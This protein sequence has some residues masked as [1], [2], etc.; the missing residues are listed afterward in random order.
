LG[1]GERARGALLGL[2]AGNA[3]GVPTEFLGS[4][5]AIR[6]AFP[7]GIRDIQPGSSANSPFDDDTAMTLLLAEE[8]LEPQVNLE[9]LAARWIEWMDTD[10][11][12]IGVQTRAALQHIA[13]T[14]LHRP[15]RVDRPETGPSCA[16]FLWRS[17]RWARPRIS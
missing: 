10:G 2:A 7:G 6:A 9:R 3:L 11:R 1:L 17:R 16:A 5:D 4:S 12:G 14:A 8:L 15:P 13:H